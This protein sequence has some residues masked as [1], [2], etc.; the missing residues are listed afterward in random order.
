MKLRRL[1]IKNVWQSRGRYLAYLA[2]SAFTVMIYFLYTALALHPYFQGDYRG[3]RYISVADNTAAIIIPMFMLVFLLYSGA[4]FNR[5]RAKE[6][7]LLALLGLSRRQLV[8]MILWENVIIAATAI[9]LGLGGGL[10]F[11]KLFFMVVSLLLGL[12]EELPVYV[13]A[14]VWWRTVGVFGAM[15]LGVSLLS[16]RTVLRLNV[17]ELVRAGRKP[18]ETPIFSWW[19]ALLGMALIVLGYAWACHPDP[20]VIVPGV[21]P[22]T[23]MVSVGTYLLMR[24][25]LIAIL[26]GLRKARRLYHRPGPFLTISYL[27]FKIQENYRMLASTAVFVA[28]IL[29]AVGTIFSFYIVSEADARLS[30]PHAVQLFIPDGAEATSE[31]AL[32]RST[33][34]EHGVQELDFV[35]VRLPFGKIGSLEVLVAPYSL[36]ESLYR[37]EGVTLPQGGDDQAIR[38]NPF[39]RPAIDPE[40]DKPTPVDL[41]LADDSIP[42]TAVTDRSGRLF[43]GFLGDVFVVSDRRFEELVADYPDVE[44]V[45]LAVWTGPGWHNSKARAAAAELTERFPRSSPVS[46]TTTLETYRARISE[47]GLALF[48]VVFTSLAFF[49]ATCS[50]LYFRLFTEIDEDRRYYTRLRQLG[51]TRGELRGLSRVQAMVIFFIPFLVGLVHSTFAMKALGTLMSHSVLV[52]GWL[53]ALGYLVVL[54]GYFLVTYA[55]YWKTLGVGRDEITMLRTA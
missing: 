32:V 46:L 26:S 4:A 47:Y 35:Q 39:R 25:S 34:A 11:L 16:L 51:L 55:L 50:L 38:V 9:A 3:A 49:A 41:L 37:P 53:V 36:Y 12:S 45:E 22:V 29:S 23:L 20:N 48:L 5:S 52:Y 21:L 8:R 17:I 42:F 44:Y 27:T 13:A 19:K 54:V 43:N 24:E 6:F 7:G 2:S 18:K 28:I 15:F 1:A 30:A 31:I 14:P 33:L 10:L 40:E